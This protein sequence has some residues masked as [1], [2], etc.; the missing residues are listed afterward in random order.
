MRPWAHAFWRHAL[1]G[2]G[3]LLMSL[4]LSW[5]MVDGLG[6]GV[7]EATAIGFVLMNLFSHHLARRWVFRVETEP[8]GGASAP[9][10]QKSLLRYLLN[11]ALVLGLNL[12]FMHWA[13]QVRGMHYLL[14]SVLLAAFFFVFNFAVQRLW[15]FRQL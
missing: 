12:L 13:V 9:A 6:V 5:L 8:A 3:C 2:G 15:A 10:Y 1:L 4:A 14:A 11:A 7:L